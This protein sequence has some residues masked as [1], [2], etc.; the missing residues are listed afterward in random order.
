[1]F[2][3]YDALMEGARKRGLKV[4]ISTLSE[5]TPFWTPRLYPEAT[6][7]DR[8]ETNLAILPRTALSNPIY[9]TVS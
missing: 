5:S 1:M 6:M 4:V 9:L 7:I 2:D 8:E 3:D